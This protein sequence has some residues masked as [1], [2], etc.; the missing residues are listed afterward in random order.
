MKDFTLPMKKREK[1]AGWI[2]LPI[3]LVLMT[4]LILP[5][6]TLL[7]ADN[8]IELDS[9]QIN[10][11]Y[12]C[13]GFAYILIFM[14]H[15]LRE[16]FVQKPKA[17]ILKT[18]LIAFAINFAL[19]YIVNLIL[20]IF[21]TQLINPNSEAVNDA[22]SINMYTMIAVAVI[23]GPIVEEVLFRGVVFGTIR[24]RSRVLAY[25]VSIL[26]FSVYHLWQTILISGDWTVLIYMVQYIP[27]GLSL[28]WA[29]EKTNSIWCSIFLHMAINAVSVLASAVV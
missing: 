3:H 27:A 5:L 14:M 6:I 11:I 12:Y 28:A 24:T 19:N 10:T 8:G 18:M 20:V 7:L 16:N 1:V 21:T 13:T 17:N 26:L 4:L 2:Y 23:L 25:I 9:V 29:Y 22:V 15:Y